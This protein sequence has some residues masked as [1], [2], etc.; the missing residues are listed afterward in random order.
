MPKFCP[1][2]LIN[3]DIVFNRFHANDKKPISSIGT[4][5]QIINFTAYYRLYR[6]PEQCCFV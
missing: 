3:I 6:L 4:I 2:V 5:L 1:N